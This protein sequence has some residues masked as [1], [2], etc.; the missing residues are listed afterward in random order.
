MESWDRAVM[1]PLGE[2]S[3][4]ATV[5]D[6]ARGMPDTVAWSNGLEGPDIPFAADPPTAGGERV[7]AQADSAKSRRSRTG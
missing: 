3:L 2:W 1:A 4:E 5:L 6:G 7:A